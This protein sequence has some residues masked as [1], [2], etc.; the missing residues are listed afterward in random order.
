V[1]HVINNTNIQYL[2]SNT[3]PSVMPLWGGETCL[4]FIFKTGINPAEFEIDLAWQVLSCDFYNF[5]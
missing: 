3:L 5:Q 1:G 2:R 4:K